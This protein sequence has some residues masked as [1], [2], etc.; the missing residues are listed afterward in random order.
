SAL[1]AM[2]SRNEA[3]SSTTLSCQNERLCR[4]SAL[5][6]KN[7]RT[8]ILSKSCGVD[9]RIDGNS[10]WKGK[11]MET[12][13]EIVTPEFK[14]PKQEQTK[15]KRRTSSRY[16]EFPHA[17]FLLS[18]TDEAG[19]RVYFFQVNITG[20]RQR[21]FGP[22]DTRSTAIESYDFFL[23]AVKEAFCNV[24]NGDSNN[25]NESADEYLSLPKDLQVCP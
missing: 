24:M 16:C 3:I 22:Y 23:F 18:G 14:P 19:K 8:H 25:A 7:F 21:V 11:T 9:P 6:W 5:A 17:R 12:K 15:S 13:L 10:D 20:L 2:I 1:R 4:F